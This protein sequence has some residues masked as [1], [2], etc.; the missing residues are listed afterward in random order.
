MPAMP[1]GG[2]RFGLWIGVA[3]GT[4]YLV[5]IGGGWWGIYL[6]TLRIITLV[7]AAIAFAA[8]A[9]V[10]ARDP[11]WRPRSNLWPAIAAV[12]GSMAVST[13]FSTDQRISAEYLGYAVLLV[14]AYLLLVRLFAHPFFGPRMATLATM[15]FALAAGA[16]LI[17]VFM[18]WLTWWSVL[19]HVTLPPLRPEF[20]SLTYG[21]PS[22]VVTL[23][24]LL[25][26][27]VAAR[28]SGPTR[29]G[30]GVLFVVGAIVAA[31]ALLSGSRA[32]W[33]ALTGTA[34]IG[35]ITWL[36]DRAHRSLVASTVRRTWASP[37]TRIAALVAIVVVAGT[38]IG[39][40]PT[41]LRR[42]TEGGEDLRASYVV[43]ALRL[44]GSA[45]L[46]GTGPGTWVIDRIAQ[47]RS[48]EVDYYIPHAH[49]VPAQ[50]LA[51]QGL[52]GALA[53]L[54]VVANVLGL[55]L[56]AIRDADPT[57]RRWG[58]L[59][60]IGLLYFALHDLLDFYPNFPAILAVAAIPLAYLDATTTP[61]PGLV[62]WRLQRP[63]VTF[64]L[65]RAM[66]VAGGL[67]VAISLAGLLLQEMPAS[68]AEAAV[69][70]ANEGRW[71]D[72][73]AGAQAAATA[74]P[75]VMPYVF[76]DGLTADR[77]GDH[78]RAAA[79]FLRVAARTDLPEAWLNLA[80]EQAHLGQTSLAMATIGKALRLGIQ[81][82]AVAI[83]AGD[84]AL[85]IGDQPDAIA[86]LAAGL[87][88]APSFAADPW[89]AT[90]PQ[91]AV[92]DQVFA[93][94]SSV[95]WPPSRWQLALEHGD[96]ASAAALA[97]AVGGSPDAV[98]ITKALGGDAAAGDALLAQCEATPLDLTGLAWCA[99]IEAS[100]G[101]EDRANDFRY[102]ANA[103][104]GGAGDAGS[105]VRVDTGTIVGRTLAGGPATFWGTYTYRR[106]TPWDILVPSLIHLRLE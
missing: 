12:L 88:E 25:A 49:D 52:V 105:I 5:F 51:E 54:I 38:A 16:F 2:A 68:A 33:L 89:W 97:P 27:P 37:A 39:A 45:P 4:A 90:G 96:L 58:W 71:A 74:D 29:R 34:V 57:R 66:T 50:T 6:P 41:I 43:V 22:A 59:T 85:R 70:A 21:N 60:F 28:F 9:I 73:S 10:A 61:G 99:R 63:R 30:I 82:P 83:A 15:L 20:E 14:A 79:D 106:N 98:R 92:F 42:L 72:A 13:L 47:T 102:L 67:A 17:R 40:S 44:F 75:D 91:A 23:V 103:V 7:V 11:A 32:G 19:G 100:R 64:Q 48:P 76:L 53:G 86:A 95:E 1:R 84:L 93:S 65:R 81:R 26:V 104:V 31:V 94:A 3:I 8:W 87:V 62:R 78:A 18:H 46:F 24:A 55:L 69:N 36:V 101:Q 77:H 80:A 35:S 56:V